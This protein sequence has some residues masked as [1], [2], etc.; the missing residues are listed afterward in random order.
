MPRNFLL[1]ID[2]ADR[3]TKIMT[4]EVFAGGNMLKAGRRSGGEAHEGLECP[5]DVSRQDECPVKE[6]IFVSHDDTIF[7]EN[8]N[9]AEECGACAAAEFAE[10]QVC[11]GN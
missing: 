4:M 11:C 5:R 7:E 8:E 2:F 9:T 1:E 10:G 3:R 6:D